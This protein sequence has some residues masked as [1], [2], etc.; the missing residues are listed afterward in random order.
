MTLLD[1]S[2]WQ[3]QDLLGGWIEGSGE[4]YPVVS[5]STG[6]QLATMGRA[7]PADVARA[8]PAPP[9]RSAPGRRA[10]YNERAAVLRRAGDLWHANA[11][12]ITGWLMRETGAIGP[13]GGFQ[14]MTSA[15]EC[16]EAAALASA[17][18]GELLRSVQPA[19]EPGAPAA[20]RGGRRDRAVQRAD[21]P[22][23]PGGGPGAGARATRCCSSRTR[24]PRSAAAPCS[25][26]SS[27]QAGLPDG[28]AA[29]AAR[30]RRGRRGPRHRARRA[31]HRLH[32]LHP[33][34]PAGGARSPRSTSSGCTSS[35]AATRRCSCSTTSTS[36]PRRR[37]G[38]WGS[39]AHQ[40]Q[41][42]MAAGRHLVQVGDRRRLRR[43]RWPRAPTT[44]RSATPPPARSRSGRSSTRA[45]AT[46]STRW[47]P[48]SVDEGAR[49]AA[50]GTYE[51]L[52]YRP[53][54]ARRRADRRR[55]PTSRRSS[56]RSRRSCASTSVDEAI[57]AR[58]ATATT[59]CP[60]A[61]S[62]AT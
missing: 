11:E 16:Y 14:I 60:S 33:G 1:G 25:P 29:R 20:G 23:D 21:D 58:R 39:F 4:P 3:G 13:F 49:L 10:P 17:P 46:R 52:F 56:D 50:G 36:T 26:R 62:P 55:R 48:A 57:A 38:A 44:C 8:A 42:C 32:R 31:G 19:A 24:G 34:R 6:E 43:P 5:P 22:V 7:T 28:R 40:G 59:G 45:S 47:S 2:A 61:S 53:D 9:R 51:D 18:Y 54:R 37:S 41:V 27:P 12:E 35:S 15:E 30:R